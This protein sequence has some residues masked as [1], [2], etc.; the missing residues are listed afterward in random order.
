MPTE[1]RVIQTG[2][3]H[4][5]KKTLSGLFLVGILYVFFCR[6]AAEDSIS[7]TVIKHYNR[8]DLINF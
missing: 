6:V 3:F 1:A 8:N 5:V 4:E 7:A 2:P